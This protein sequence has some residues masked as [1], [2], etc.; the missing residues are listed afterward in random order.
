MPWSWALEKLQTC[1]DFWLAT[2]RPDGR[3]HLAPVWCL[4]L[5]DALYFSTAPSSRKGRNLALNANCCVSTDGAG[6]TVIVDGT[7][8]ICEDF[9]LRQRVAELYAA[10]YAWVLTATETGVALDDGITTPLYVIKPRTVL[11]MTD[12]VVSRMTRWRFTN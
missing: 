8:S 2:V 4:W 5:D 10:K 6:A 7:V 1:R 12:E 9:A 3:P 11:G